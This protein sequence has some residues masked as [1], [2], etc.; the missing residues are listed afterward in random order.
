LTL[1]LKKEIFSPIKVSVSS[2]ATENVKKEYFLDIF[3]EFIRLTADMGFSHD[4]TP[5]SP[6]CTKNRKTNLLTL[7]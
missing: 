2:L 7:H 5:S 1:E 6:S 3:I 4:F